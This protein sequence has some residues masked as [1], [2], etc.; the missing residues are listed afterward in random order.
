MVF[1]PYRRAN[2]VRFEYQ[3]DTSAERPGARE[4]IIGPPAK[5][6]TLL[7]PAY[8]GSNPLPVSLPFIVGGFFGIVKYIIIY[9]LSDPLSKKRAITH[10]GDGLCEKGDNPCPYRV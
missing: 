10:R 8:G 6:C 3:S 9:P 7:V 2:N 1:K 4:A 5:R